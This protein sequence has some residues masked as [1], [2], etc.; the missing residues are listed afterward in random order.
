MTR[1]CNCRPAKGCT[2]TYCYDDVCRHKNVVY[3]ATCMTTNK[4]YI[5]CT[6]QDL[7]KR[8]QQHYEDVK[9]LYKTG[10]KSDSFASHF[11]SLLPKGLKNVTSPIIRNLLS[12]KYEVLWEGKP[13]STNKTYGTTYC[14][15]CAKER[16]A[17][18]RHK[19]EKENQVINTNNEIY[20]ACRHKPKFHRYSTT[21]D[22]TDDSI[23]MKES[24]N[25]T[26]KHGKKR[27]LQKCK[28]R[29]TVAPNVLSQVL[30]RLT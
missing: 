23:R 11:A 7:K 2:S 14:T 10:I 18:I 3:K 12:V 15:L 4:C 25:K 20:G 26:G 21:G 22:S 19:S 1:D 8:M 30:A 16:I 13:L 17:I 6:Q 27:N 24:K 9:K 29:K 5:G 28:S